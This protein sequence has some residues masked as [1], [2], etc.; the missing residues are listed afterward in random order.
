M[1]QLAC[2]Q[3]ALHRL[4]FLLAS[5][6]AFLHACLMHLQSLSQLFVINGVL[7]SG[8]GAAWQFMSSN[9]RPC[10]GRLWVAV[11]GQDRDL[12]ARNQ[13]LAC[14]RSWRPSGLSPLVFN[15]L[16]QQMAV[17]R[18]HI[19]LCGRQQVSATGTKHEGT[20]Q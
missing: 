5:L 12:S 4:A 19:L 3:R 9:Q 13:V 11:Q 15:D 8:R 10:P 7:C 18:R 2:L 17:F 20:A 6:L 1:R 16:R 14:H